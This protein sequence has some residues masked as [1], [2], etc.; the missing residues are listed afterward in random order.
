MKLCNFALAGALRA[1]CADTGCNLLCFSGLFL[2]KDM[3]SYMYEN[4]ALCR[5]YI[6]LY[7]VS[8]GQT[9]IYGLFCEFVAPQKKTLLLFSVRDMSWGLI[10]PC[11]TKLLWSIFCKWPVINVTLLTLKIAVDKI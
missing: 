3:L 5:E 9:E 4:I 11:F 7:Y 6:L 10:N 2:K 8:R 1:T